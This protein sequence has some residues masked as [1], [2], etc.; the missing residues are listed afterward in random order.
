MVG[1]KYLCAA[2]RP[3]DWEDKAA[4][5]LKSFDGDEKKREEMVRQTL[6]T[7]KEKIQ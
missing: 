2:P 4:A 6:K 1:R 3:D 5:L 7:L